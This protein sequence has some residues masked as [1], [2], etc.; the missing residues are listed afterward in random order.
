MKIRIIAEGSTPEDRRTENWGLSLL[1]G[2][3]TLFD[4]FGK[5][6]LFLHNARAFGVDLG[7]L[8]HVALSHDHWDHVSGLWDVLGLNNRVEIFICPRTR[9]EIR[10]RIVASGARV[11]EAREFLEVGEGIYTTGEMPGIAGGSVIH[12]QAL[13]VRSPRGLSLITG[14]AHPGI[15]GMVAQVRERFGMPVRCVAG[16]LHLKDAPD[17]EVAHLVAQLTELGVRRVIPLHCTGEPAVR[18]LRAAFGAQ[19]IEAREGHVFEV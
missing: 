11:F 13:V 2:N 3:D 5:A 15:A 8:A 10:D 1:L 7:K 12:E 4:T 19:C 9:Q 18:Q 14:C 6:S 16:G 17:E